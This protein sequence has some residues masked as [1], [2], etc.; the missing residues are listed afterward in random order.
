[1]MRAILSLGCVVAL[2]APAIA[3]KP[4]YGQPSDDLSVQAI[5]NFAEC[6]AD[7]TPRGAEEL[8]ALD[9]RSAEYGKRLDRLT[10]GHADGRCT[11]AS[12]MQFDGVLLAGG[13]A[14]RLLVEKVKPESFSRLVVYDATKGPIQAR[15][16]M[17]MTSICVVRAE[18]AKTFAIFRSDPTSADESHAMQA[19]APTLMSCIKAGQKI[20]L[21]K[22][23]LRAS[24]ALAAYRLVNQP[25]P[26]A[27]ADAKPIFGEPG[28]R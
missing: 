15:S 5:H 13:M 27:S 4:L 26:I 28:S 19:I 9:Y 24:L 20:T 6:V 8:L 11:Y 12:R 22:P 25:E 3:A 7:T 18:P 16:A 17:E 1:M 21:N 23:G 2:V 10:Q 14:E